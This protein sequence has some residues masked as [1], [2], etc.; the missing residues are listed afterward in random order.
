MGLFSFDERT[1]R[2]LNRLVYEAKTT[3][4]SLLHNVP[5][6]S[7]PSG[8]EWVRM[9][10]TLHPGQ[11]GKGTLLSWNST[12]NIYQLSGR[13]A[14]QTIYD[15]HKW[16]FVIGDA[17]YAATVEN[18]AVQQN[19]LNGRFEV[20][21]P[22]GLIRPCKPDANIATGA[23]GTWSIYTDTGVDTTVNV[24]G[25]IKWADNAEGVSANKESWIKWPGTQW[26]WI[27]G[28]CE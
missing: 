15:P 6:N 8:I 3:A 23:T 26:T 16:A 24:S 1:S 17:D 13:F 9:Q 25:E 19:P 11:S 18:V 27:G 2:E 7:N 22:I 5:R 10:D 28:D 20:I 21:S 4:A 14:N 12:L